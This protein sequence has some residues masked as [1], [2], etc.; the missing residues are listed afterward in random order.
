MTT[1][2]GFCMRYG[3]GDNS[4]CKLTRRCRDRPAYQ[5]VSV[6]TGHHKSASDRE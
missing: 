2:L 4:V 3:E 5:H 1:L 6:R